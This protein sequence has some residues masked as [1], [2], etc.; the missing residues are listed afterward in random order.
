MSFRPNRVALRWRLVAP[1]ASGCFVG[2]TERKCHGQGGPRPT[3]FLSGGAKKAEAAQPAAARPAFAPSWPDSIERTF[4]ENPLS[5][6]VHCALSGAWP[7]CGFKEGLRSIVGGAVSHRAGSRRSG[8]GRNYRRSD[9]QRIA[10]ARRLGEVPFD[11][12]P[13]L[14]AKAAGVEVALRGPVFTQ[15]VT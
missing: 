14:D 2:G 15:P 13:V 3:G 11:R 1:K 7:G 4:P 10:G 12:L 5:R 8:G 9:K 6:S